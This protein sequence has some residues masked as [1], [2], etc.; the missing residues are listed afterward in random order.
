MTTRELRLAITALAKA[1]RSRRYGPDLRAAVVE[2]ARA[3]MAQGATAA[4]ICR[5]LDISEPTL[6]R[7]LAVER[8][9]RRK[10][11][12]AEFRQ[13]QV[14]ADPADPAGGTGRVTVHGPA[15]L[16]IEGLPVGDVVALWRELS[17]LG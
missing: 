4:G 3:R 2:H 16:L 1:K 6:A 14:V 7:F 13:V 17:C 5:E 8:P 12:I 11:V 15:G 10:S 9:Q